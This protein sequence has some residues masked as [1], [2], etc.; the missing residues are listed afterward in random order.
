MGHLTALIR[1]HIQKA[2]GSARD[3]LLAFSRS[4]SRLL[5]LEIGRH[6]RPLDVSRLLQLQI[7]SHP[8]PLD[9]PPLTTLT[10]PN[11]A[12]LL[13]ETTLRLTALTN[14]LVD[15]YVSDMERC[16]DWIPSLRD[17]SW[18]HVADEDLV[19]LARATQL[20]EVLL[21]GGAYSIVG[22]HNLSRLPELEKIVIAGHVSFSDDSL[23]LLSCIRG[24]A[25]LRCLDLSSCEQLTDTACYNVVKYWQQL[26]VLNIGWHPRITPA[27]IWH[28]L[29]GLS[30]LRRICIIGCTAEYLECAMFTSI[31]ALLCAQR[32]RVMGM[33]QVEIM[34]VKMVAAGGQTVS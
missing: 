12:A 27:G 33:Q 5:E 6:P 14:L 13:T 4:L 20:R 34:N 3:T 16:L 30:A 28:V 10:F 25:R 31:D 23:L 26:E 8:R 2:A 17:L 24:F 19:A 9:V 11:M 15:D 18:D 22:L 32:R 1:L 29:L 21:G 7:Q